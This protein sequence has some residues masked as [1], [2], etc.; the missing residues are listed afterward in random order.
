MDFQYSEEQNLL[1]DSLKRLIANDYSFEARKKIIAGK[2]M[3]DAVWQQLAEL[4]LMTLPFS[5]AHGGFDAGAM[6][7]LP[8]MQAIGEGLLL[9]PYLQTVLVGRIVERSGSDAQKSAVLPAIMEGSLKAAVAYL[10]A[11]SRYNAN[12]V[13]TAAKADGAGWVLS[14]EKVVVTHAHLVD[15]LV[16]SARTSGGPLDSSGISLFLVDAKAA[17]VTMKTERSVDNQ[18]SADI[19]FDQVKLGADALIGNAGEGF[20]VL[21]EALDFASVLLC[22][23]AV[24]AMNSANVATLEYIKTRKQFGVAIGSFQALQHRM[25]DMTIVTRQADSI[26]LLAAHAV[27][28]AARGL[29]SVT[30]RRHVVA[31]ARVKMADACRQVGQEAIQL[32][33]GMGMTQE[34]KVSH[35]FKRLTMLSQTIGDADH[36]LERFAATE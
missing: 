5:E 31:A 18:R 32:H 9:E 29:M 15:K 22:G 13:S 10:E 26:A 30:E 16:V 28:Q 35:T 2:G 24:G 34:M 17:G 25:V 8:T 12:D 7:M 36:Y 33:G 6:G 1:A 14:G 23:E 20:E 3:S 27:D 19:R 11:Q 21:D 4:G